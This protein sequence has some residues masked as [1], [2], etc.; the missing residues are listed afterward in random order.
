MNFV[1]IL[2]D[3]KVTPGEYILHTPTNQVV[4]CGAFSRD[5]ETFECSLAEKCSPTRYTTLRR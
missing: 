5:M 2:E 1:D 3:T 4:L